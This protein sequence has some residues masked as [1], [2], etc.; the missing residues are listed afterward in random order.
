MF[1]ADIQL[2]RGQ[3]NAEGS[4][5]RVKRRKKAKTNVHPV[6]FTVLF[7]V[8]ETDREALEELQATAA[9]VLRE[10][11]EECLANPRRGLHQ[12]PELR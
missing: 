1:D 6:Y 5:V 7:S 10:M 9:D 3:K 8:W 4:R 2:T 11:V 12:E